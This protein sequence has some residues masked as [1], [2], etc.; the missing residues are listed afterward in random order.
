[1]GALALGSASDSVRRSTSCAPSRVML[2]EHGPDLLLGVG[3]S[4]TLLASGL[5]ALRLDV[6]LLHAAT[7][8]RSFDRSLP[9]EIA[10]RTSRSGRR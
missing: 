1:M 4:N 2:R 10:S 8:L 5:V 7:S 3:D 6:K 9:Q